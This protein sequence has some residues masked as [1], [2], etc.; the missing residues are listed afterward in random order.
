MSCKLRGARICKKFKPFR[1][2]FGRAR[3]ELAEVVE[4]LQLSRASLEYHEHQS[5]TWQEECKTLIL[6]GR[7]Q[8][9]KYETDILSM[10][11][12]TTMLAREITVL[13][14]R[15]GNGSLYDDALRTKCTKIAL[16]N[17]SF[18]S[19]MWDTERQLVLA[20]RGEADMELSLKKTDRDTQ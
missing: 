18:V 14:A 7:E 16:E 3:A 12:E 19:R 17:E 9:A 15:V 20:R 4:H 8:E 2:E 11:S 5:Y 1:K 10:K 6:R 13:R